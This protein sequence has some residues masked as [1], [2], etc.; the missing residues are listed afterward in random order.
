[1]RRFINKVWRCSQS[2]ANPSPF[3]FSV[4]HP[5]KHG[6]LGT[7]TRIASIDRLKSPGSARFSQ[8]SDE[9]KAWEKH[10]NASA[11]T[12]MPMRGITVLVRAVTRHEN[13]P[14]P[15][16]TMTEER[17]TEALRGLD[18]WRQVNEEAEVPAVFADPVVAA[19][20]PRPATDPQPR[21][22]GS[23]ANRYPGTASSSPP[24]R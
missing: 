22:D 5:E 12:R 17:N 11:R 7:N 3:D 21:T 18:P 1:M 9:S 4:F 15:G 19:P 13:G 23:A 2:S 14:S 16:D 20:H 10:G 24:C 8:F 6:K